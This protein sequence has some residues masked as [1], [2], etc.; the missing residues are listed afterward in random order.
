MALQ[1]TFHLRSHGVY[2][3]F[4]SVSISYICCIGYSVGMSLVEDTDEENC[5]PRF[6]VNSYPASRAQLTQH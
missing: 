6:R 3:V 4:V 1:V 2:T 5:C